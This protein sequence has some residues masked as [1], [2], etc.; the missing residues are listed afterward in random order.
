MPSV[1]TKNN[2][3]KIDG[4]FASLQAGESRDAGDDAA[5]PAGRAH[6]ARIVHI[7]GVSDPGQ[8]LHCVELGGG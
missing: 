7:Q 4:V 8:Q 2:C 6:G 1:C 5:L 3:T